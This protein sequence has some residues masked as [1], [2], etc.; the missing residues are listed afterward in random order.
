MSDINSYVWKDARIS[1]DKNEVQIETKLVDMDEDQ[2]QM[3]YSHCKDMLYNTNPTN[4]GRMIIIDQIAHQIDNCGAELALRWFKTLRDTNGNELYDNE[5]LLKEIQSWIKAL[6]GY[7]SSERYLLGDFVSVPNEYRKVPINSLIEA[8]KDSLGNFNHSK[9][10]YSFIYNHLGIYLTQEELT[11]IDND[12]INAGINPEKIT[13]QQK[14]DNHVKFPL[15]I[16]NADIKINSRG[17]T[18]SELKDFIHMK[19]LK[20]YK[21]CKY[22]SLTTSQLQ[23]LRNKILIALENRTLWQAKKWQEIMSQ[24]EEVAKYKH[25]QLH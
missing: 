21:T 3:I 20:G 15:G 24:I 7:N 17:L 8:C 14:I 2:L 22:S 19:K 18:I 10:S 1:R 4:E 9:I 25:F 6:T 5:S 11:E 12:L 23:T 13:L 16:S